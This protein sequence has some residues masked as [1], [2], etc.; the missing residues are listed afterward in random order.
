ML[1]SA[2][3]VSERIEVKVCDGNLYCELGANKSKRKP[4]VKIIPL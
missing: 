3:P 2:K 1:A 4:G